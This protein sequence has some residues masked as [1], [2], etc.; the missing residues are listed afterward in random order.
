TAGWST[1]DDGAAAVFHQ[2]GADEPAAWLAYEHLRAR[3]DDGGGVRRGDGA[4]RVDQPARGVRA[5]RGGVRVD[6]VP[7]AGDEREGARPRG[8]GGGAGAWSDLPP[9]RVVGGGA[10]TIR[11]GRA[12][13]RVAHGVAWR[14]SV[15]AGVRGPV[16]AGTERRCG[17]ARAG[18]RARAD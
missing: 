14:E 5:A 17:G 16:D 7:Q 1:R 10:E 8:A 13:A 15:S 2:R 4:A 9:V 18:E 12:G 11:G 3:H 6:G